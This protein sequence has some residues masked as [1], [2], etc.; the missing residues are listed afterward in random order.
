MV[1]TLAACG[2]TDEKTAGGEGKKYKVGLV[3][4]NQTDQFTAWQA[5]EL[6]KACEEKYNDKFEIEMIDGGGDNAKIIAGMETFISK[7]VDV[8]FV[9]PND[10]ESLIPT[11][12][13]AY[14]NDIIVITLGE[15]VE[16][17]KSTSILSS[18]Q[19]QN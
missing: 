9:Q 8:I 5:N 16:D 15:K 1:F 7:G 18:G 10:T 6:V 4:K 14:E 17:G 11:I 13:Q 19:L 3:A 12:N 2:K